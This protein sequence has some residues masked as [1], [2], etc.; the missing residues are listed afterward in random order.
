M[1]LSDSFIYNSFIEK[2]LLVL[3]GYFSKLP[4]IVV[5]YLFGSIA[6]NMY[7]KHSDVDIAILFSEKMSLVD[8]FNLK[9][10]IASELE[11]LLDKK[12]DV[13]DL[14]CADAFFIHKIMEERILVYEKDIKM[15]VE[16]EVRSR[17]E[18]FDRHRFYK[19]YHTRA[20]KRLEEMGKYVR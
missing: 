12:I 8:R 15:R 20:M 6:K 17:K 14:E 9:L 2:T 7:R 10:Q 11:D 1:D 5:V 13:V 16:F 19:L 3:T 18:F 4:D